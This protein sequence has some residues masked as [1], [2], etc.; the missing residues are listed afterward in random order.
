VNMGSEYFTF[1]SFELFLALIV[2]TTVT[3]YSLVGGFQCFRG[4]CC[5]HLQDQIR[6]NFRLE[7]Q[8][9]KQTG[10]SFMST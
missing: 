7:V 5:L 8:G 6:T 10:T 1:A 2:E 4:T 3:P 9:H